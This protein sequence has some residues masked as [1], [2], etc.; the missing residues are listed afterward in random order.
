MKAHGFFDTSVPQKAAQ[1]SHNIFQK[2]LDIFLDNC[3]TWTFSSLQA[4]N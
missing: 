2:A 1:Y 4:Q 3:Y